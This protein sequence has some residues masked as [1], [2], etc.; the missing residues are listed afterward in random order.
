MIELFSDPDFVFVNPEVLRECVWEREASPR[1]INKY[2]S[3]MDVCLSQTER[4][5]GLKER[6]WRENGS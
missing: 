5:K 1:D 6:N 4:M 3:I 2:Q